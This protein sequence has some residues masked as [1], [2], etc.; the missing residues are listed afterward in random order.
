MN[1]FT[2]SEDKIAGFDNSGAVTLTGVEDAGEFFFFPGSASRS[3]LPKTFS[4]GKPSPSNNL[5]VSV[6]YKLQG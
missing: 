4:C 3:I 6:F 5:S 1:S 2:S